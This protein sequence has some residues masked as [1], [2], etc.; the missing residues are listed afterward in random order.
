MKAQGQGVN[1]NSIPDME[2]ETG[3]RIIPRA[4]FAVELW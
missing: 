2:E 3:G 1:I 4:A